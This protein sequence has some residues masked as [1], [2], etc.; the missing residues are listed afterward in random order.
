MKVNK[1]TPYSKKDFT[2][3]EKSIGR[4]L[5]AEHREKLNY[6]KL[7]WEASK[8][9][10]PAR[11]PT[12]KEL[13]EIRRKKIDDIKNRIADLI[14]L[15]ESDGHLISWHD[16]Y[17]R[18]TDQLYLALRF[19]ETAQKEKGKPSKKV[20]A[21]KGRTP[22]V[23]RATFI[24]ELAEIFENITGEKAAAP[25]YNDYIGTYTCKNTFLDFAV[26][27]IEPVETIQHVTLG[28]A[29]KKAFAK[30]KKHP[31]IKIQ[32]KTKLGKPNKNQIFPE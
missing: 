6:S 28:S 2:V 16:S 12:E 26:S 5:T 19:T 4:K 22:E 9:L 21:R 25:A 18:M 29:I 10:L 17:D 30:N 15:L 32:V 23:Y 24:L 8:A 1:G 14:E 27:C 3:I 20:V 7:R 31:R 13:Q 11:I